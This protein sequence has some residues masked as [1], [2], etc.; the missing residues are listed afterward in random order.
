[1]GP[2]TSV[3][4]SFG[5][6]PTQAI[7]D[8]FAWHS[9]LL[10]TKHQ[11]ILL[12]PLSRLKMA[13]DET[14][15][16]WSSIVKFFSANRKFSLKGAVPYKSAP[17]CSTPSL[18]A[19]LNVFGHISAKKWSDFHS[20]KTN[21]KVEKPYL[22]EVPPNVFSLCPAPLLGNLRYVVFAPFSWKRYMYIIIMLYYF[23]P[24]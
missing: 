19:F 17:P 4:H 14:T 23:L 21:W 16:R 8:L 10:Y 3:Q 15:D 18:L 20:V 2:A 5:M 9:P 24:K 11:I 13:K 7:R 12:G 22:V 6:T 1:M